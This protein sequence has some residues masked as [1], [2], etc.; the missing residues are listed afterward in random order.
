M[1]STEL[2]IGKLARQGGVNIQTIRYYERLGLIPKPNRSSS[3]YRLYDEE[4]VRR[5]G[6]VRKAQLLGFSLHEIDE[7]LSL[8]M[9]PGITCADIRMRAR[10]KIATV[11]EKIA[12]LTRIRGALAKLATAC[13]GEGPTSECPILEAFDAHRS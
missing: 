10:Q 6:F 9:R 2:T 3:G 7:L 5:L 11:V 1:A 8:R 12:E 13:R 4:T